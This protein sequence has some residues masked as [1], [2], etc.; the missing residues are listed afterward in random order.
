MQKE[1]YDILSNYIGQDY[2]I[3]ECDCD[4]DNWMVVIE[5]KEY[6]LVD[7]VLVC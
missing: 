4:C 5:V 3:I 1:L 6:G 2:E 7:E